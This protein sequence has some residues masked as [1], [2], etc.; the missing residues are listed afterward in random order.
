MTT[1]S[2]FCCKLYSILIH[3]LFGQLSN[4][5]RTHTKYLER[6]TWCFCDVLLWIFNEGFPPISPKGRLTD[7][8]GETV[9][10][11]E[12]LF[13]MT[14]NLGSDAVT[15]FWKKENKQSGLYRCRTHA[16]NYVSKRNEFSLYFRIRSLLS[17]E[18][19]HCKQRK[20]PL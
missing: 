1:F 11:N 7:G 5:I 12:A 3:I 18:A 16:F 4:R 9:M 8:K 17:T 19:N 10:C 6:E 20:L 13:F 15:D 14:S 2:L